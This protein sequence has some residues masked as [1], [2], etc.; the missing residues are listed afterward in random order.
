MVEII[1]NF[2][3]LSAQFINTIFLFEVE[4][5]T[6]QYVPLGKIATAFVFIAVSIYLILDAFGILDKGE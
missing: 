1:K 6:G 5:N 4:F 3:D 2:L